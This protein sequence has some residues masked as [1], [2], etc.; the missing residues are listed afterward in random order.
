VEERDYLGIP[1]AAVHLHILDRINAINDSL[2]KKWVPA[3]ILV[4]VHS[5][6]RIHPTNNVIVE[7]LVQLTNCCLA[8]SWLDTSQ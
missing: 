8:V 1:R 2:K 7:G 4:C 3:Y 5:G 6:N